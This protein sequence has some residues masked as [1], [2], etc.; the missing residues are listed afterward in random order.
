MLGNKTQGFHYQRF[1]WST[2]WEEFVHPKISTKC[3]L[4]ASHCGRHWRQSAE[5]ETTPVLRG[6]SYIIIP[7][8]LLQL[9]ASLVAQRLKRLPAMRETWVRSLGLEDPLEKEMATH[10]SIVAWRIPWTEEP[11]GLQS[12]GLQR[13]GHDWETSFSLS[14]SRGISEEDRIY[15]YRTYTKID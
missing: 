11:R 6:W 8:N 9:G 7:G 3:L 12:A 15:S 10:S 5:K 4:C 13:V 14:L 2:M 1:L